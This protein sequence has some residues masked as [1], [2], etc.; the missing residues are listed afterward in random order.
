[1]LRPSIIW[2]LTGLAFAVPCA[3][4]Q[5]RT[6]VQLPTFNRTT[7]GTTVSVPDR[8]TAL[9]G[10]VNRAAEGSTTRGVPGLSKLPGANR[11][12]Q[13]RGIG[14]ETGAMSMTVTPRVIDLQEEELRQTGFSWDD[15]PRAAGGGFREVRSEGGPTDPAPVRQAAFL[16]RNVARH[17]V[18][19]ARDRQ[20]PEDRTESLA[21]IRKQHQR[22]ATARA[23]EAERYYAEGWR[24]ESSGQLG[25]A[26]IYYQMALRRAEGPQREAIHARLAHL[27]GP[28]PP[29]DQ[30]ADR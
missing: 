1:M 20:V 21:T 27:D 29:V 11:L 13:N 28:N 10:G 24:A 15:P 22:Q 19:A 4:A 30:L 25:V 23:D 2:G 18:P 3:E 5:Q 6:T 16:A 17:D 14:R 12:F 8:G 9:L 7:V 26:R